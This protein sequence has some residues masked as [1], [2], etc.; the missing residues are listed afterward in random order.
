MASLALARL[1]ALRRN[2]WWF[3]SPHFGFRTGDAKVARKWAHASI[4]AEDL[5]RD[6]IDVP[7]FYQLSSGITDQ[8]K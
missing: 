5:H 1:E 6:W 8:W 2:M 3:L 4:P 7:Y